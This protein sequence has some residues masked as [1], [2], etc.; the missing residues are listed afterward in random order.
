MGW[1]LH[2]MLEEVLEDP[3]K[4]TVEQL[5]LRVKQLEELSDQELKSLG[6][7][8]KQTKEQ[9]DEE[10]IKKLHSKHGVGE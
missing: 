10:E 9:A 3:K 2:A 5:S 8:G 1:I 7:K 4:N 6:E